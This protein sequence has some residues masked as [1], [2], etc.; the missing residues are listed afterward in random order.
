MAD[1]L[2]V[3]NIAGMA[4]V[5]DMFYVADVVENGTPT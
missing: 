2:Y 1:M 5:I 3:A 4:D